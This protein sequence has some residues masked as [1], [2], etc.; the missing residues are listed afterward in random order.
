MMEMRTQEK[1]QKTPQAESRNETLQCLLE[2]GKFLGVFLFAL[3]VFNV[4]LEMHYIPSESMEPTISTG[5]YVLCDRASYLF[6]DY[7]GHRGDIVVFED[8]NGSGSLLIK[9]VI[10]VAGDIVE[11]KDGD[12]YLNGEL[13]EEP[14]IKTPHSTYSVQDSYTVPENSMFVMGDNRE[15]SKDSR[16]FA[17]PFVETSAVR[18]RMLG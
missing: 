18:S 9:R 7:A 2:C 8:P 14:Y 3:F 12:V 15:N 16:F 6:K 1:Q 17:S 10:A 5:S 4:I 13:S 11:F